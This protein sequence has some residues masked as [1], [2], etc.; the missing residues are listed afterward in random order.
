MLVDAASHTP[1]ASAST[2]KR[3]SR[4]RRFRI[5]LHSTALHCTALHTARS[6]LVSSA[7]AALIPVLFTIMLSIVLHRIAR[8]PASRSVCR[9]GLAFSFPIGF[10]TRR[11]RGDHARPTWLSLLACELVAGLQATVV[12]AAALE[13]QRSLSRSFSRMDRPAP[14][15]AAWRTEWICSRQKPVEARSCRG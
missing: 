15:K 6:N 11:K 10:P 3:P 1:V 8:A 5:C 4:K 14:A 2:D 7:A 12:T 13:P 9:C